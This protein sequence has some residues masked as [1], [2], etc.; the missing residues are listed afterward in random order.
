MF[1]AEFEQ[2]VIKA[3]REIVK[4][5]LESHV[6]VERRF[7]QSQ[8]CKELSI[9]NDTLIEMNKRGLRPTKI[10]R[11]YIYLESDVNKFLKEHQI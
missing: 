10:G 5:V 4:D 6:Q 2:E 11:Q 7:N 8:L 3:V 9:G 1:S